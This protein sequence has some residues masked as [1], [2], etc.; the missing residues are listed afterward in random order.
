MPTNTTKET[1]KSVFET[2][3]N[4]N[5]KVK[6]K[7]DGDNA[8]TYIS[9]S[10]AWGQLLEQYPDATYEVHENPATFLPIYSG[11]GV[12]FVKVSVTV[13]GKTNTEYYPIMDFRKKAIPE[14]K[15]NSNDVYN[16]IQRGLTKCIARFGLGLYIY[17]GEEY[18]P[19]LAEE[20]KELE[21]RKPAT[22]DAK[23]KFIALCKENNLDASA[24]VTEIGLEK[25]KSLT[26]GQ[27]EEAIKVC[28]AIIEK[29]YEP[30]VMKL[31]DF[32]IKEKS[33]AEK[34][35]EKAEKQAEKPKAKVEEVSKEKAE[36][37]GSKAPVEA[38]ASEEEKQTLI[39]YC[40]ENNLK[41]EDILAEAGH[42]MGNG[43]L[44]K[45]N[46]DK[47]FAIAKSKVA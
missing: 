35:K 41:I 42:E 1:K 43:K 2:L 28:K 31:E 16:A 38:L 32:A 24:I 25:G 29:V 7:G 17:E 12:A 34:P 9:W 21:K 19:E 39:D 30:K 36:A 10:E 22:K 15:L 5:V 11:G 46:C 47:A 40:K 33:K 26:R 27:L 4:I 23:T 44:S 14:D 18:P 3:R 6:K 37:K 8:L 13:E 45:E 20:K